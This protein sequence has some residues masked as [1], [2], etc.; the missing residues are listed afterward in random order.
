MK[1]GRRGLALGILAVAGSL[2][3]AGGAWT[4][5]QTTPTQTAPKPKVAAG[6]PAAK[7]AVAKVPAKAAPNGEE[8]AENAFI[9]I[10]DLKGISVN[11]FMDTM[12]FFSASLSWNCTDCH[13]EDAVDDWKNFGNDT[14]RKTTAR[15]MIRMVNALNKN[16]FGGARLVTCFTCHRGDANPKITPSLVLQYSTPFEDPN[17]VTAKAGQQQGMPTPD[18]ILAKYFQAI[19]G[20][21]KVA[22]IKSFTA[23]GTYSGYDTDNQQKPVELYAKAPAQ[24]TQI[25]H[26]GLGDMVRVFDGKTGWISSPDRPRPLIALTVGD[27]TGA[28]VDATI[29]FPTGLKALYPTWRTAEATIDDNDTYMIEGTAPGQLPLRL[30]FDEKTGFLVRVVR[31]TNTVVGFDPTQLDFSDYREVPGTGVKVPFHR[32]VTWTD[33]QTTTDLTEVHLNA[34]VDDAKFTQ[35]PPAKPGTITTLGQ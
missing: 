20:E 17:E 5:A 27:I 28:K 18:A 14:P 2:C 24:Q 16:N 34:T 31:M 21:D 23:K 10:T 32:I 30:Y 22:A 9:S 15:K 26:G 6:A 1:F 25:V 29:L 33:N 35:P 3:L 11:E 13:G 8:L 12:G 4:G 19:G 7:K